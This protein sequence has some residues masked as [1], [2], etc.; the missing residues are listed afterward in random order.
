MK[1]GTIE[2]EEQKE[3][4]EAKNMNEDVKPKALETYRQEQSKYRELKEK[5]PREGK[6]VEYITSRNSTKQIQRVEGEDSKR[7]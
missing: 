1:A 4:D 3:K 5:I 6:C 2:E 7:R